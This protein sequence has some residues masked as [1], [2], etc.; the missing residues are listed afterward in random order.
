[1]W[2]QTIENLTKL[3]KDKQV[4]RVYKAL[5]SSLDKKEFNGK[6]LTGKAADLIVPRSCSGLLKRR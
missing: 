6:L 1:M 4:R 3:R 2:T 5:L